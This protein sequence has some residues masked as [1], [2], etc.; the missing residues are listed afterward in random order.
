MNTK[1]AVSKIILFDREVY[2]DPY[3]VG[4]IFRSLGTVFR[5]LVRLELPIIHILNR[6]LKKFQLHSFLIE[7]PI[8]HSIYAIYLSICLLTNIL[9]FRVNWKKLPIFK[10]SY[11]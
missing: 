5:N 9:T 6:E 8:L 3:E 4:S 10:D 7:M 11:Y 1:L 2:F